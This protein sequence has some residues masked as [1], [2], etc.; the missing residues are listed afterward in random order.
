MA[1]CSHVAEGDIGNLASI[2]DPADQFGVFVAPNV[3]DV[4]PFLGGSSKL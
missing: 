3:F 1:L 2:D 4:G